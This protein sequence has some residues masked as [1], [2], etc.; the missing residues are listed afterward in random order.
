MILK[1]VAIMLDLSDMDQIL[2][3]YVRRL[4]ENYQFEAVSFVHFM[5]VEEMPE[6]ILSLFPDLDEPVDEMIAEEIQEQVTETF[7]EGVNSKIYVHTGGD[8]QKFLGWLE[9]SDFDLVVL[10]KKAALHGSG[11]FSSKLVRLLDANTLFV[12]EMARGDIHRVMVPI[13]FSSYTN[14]TL[15]VAREAAE[16]LQAELLPVHA[17]K[18]NLHYYPLFK[19]KKEL[20]QHFI[21]ST[22]KK[23]EKY[24][25]KLKLKEDCKCVVLEEDA[26]VSKALY[27]QAT[28]N[29]ADLVVIGNKGKADSNDLLIGSVAERLIS[30]E[31]S[32]PV[33]IVKS[34]S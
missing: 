18:L 10:G 29:S 12:T 17:V 4:H 11:I 13:D 9:Q 28:F 15:K 26:H 20:E 33:L 30:H 6:E 19:D 5:E 3:N 2:L 32:I 27:D 21:K 34:S 24:K 31:K 14:K 22:R 25:E 16:V 7:V 8:M 1:R 23:F